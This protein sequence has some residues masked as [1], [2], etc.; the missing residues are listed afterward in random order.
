M[1]FLRAKEQQPKGFSSLHY[2]NET[3]E[4]NSLHRLGQDAFRGKVDSMKAMF[5]GNT[6][7][8]MSDMAELSKIDDELAVLTQLF[9]K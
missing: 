4:A 2:S 3:R 1:L 6:E 8:D 9:Q 5:G 7:N